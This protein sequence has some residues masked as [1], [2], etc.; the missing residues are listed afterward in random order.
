MAICVAPLTAS[1][2]GPLAVSCRGHF[3]AASWSPLAPP[4]RHL[5][6]AYLQHLLALLGHLHTTDVTLACDNL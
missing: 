5:G 3:T 1:F 4:L 2:G 6:P